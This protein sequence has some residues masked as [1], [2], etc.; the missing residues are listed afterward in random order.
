[1]STSF[2]PGLDVEDEY[3]YRELHHWHY[4]PS[5]VVFFQE[6]DE[7]R[8]SQAIAAHNRSLPV[9]DWNK[10][11]PE[12]E[13]TPSID[14]GKELNG[15]SVSPSSWFLEEEKTEEE[16]GN[17]G[18]EASQA[19]EDEFGVEGTSGDFFDLLGSELIDGPQTRDPYLRSM[20]SPIG[21]GTRCVHHH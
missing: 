2:A 21:I 17:V 15:N 13:I 6:S 7:W 12:R 19:K 11:R 14:D 16:D 1:M 20:L 4:H 9:F 3:N 8:A 18:L 10:N 5:P